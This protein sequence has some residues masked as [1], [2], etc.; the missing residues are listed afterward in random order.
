MAAE[1]APKQENRQPEPSG[2]A[3]QSRFWLK[4]AMAQ[5]GG[6]EAFLHW[7]RSDGG[8]ARL[9]LV[10]RGTNVLPLRIG[11]LKVAGRCAGCQ[12]TPRQCI[13]NL[14]MKRIIT[15]SF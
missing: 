4:E 14:G 12:P 6:S 3:E 13:L 15:A 9:R 8:K 10:R 1:E 7:L 2:S 11:I 5:R